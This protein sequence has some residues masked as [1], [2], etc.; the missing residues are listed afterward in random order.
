MKTLINLLVVGGDSSLYISV[1]SY[2]VNRSTGVHKRTVS[3]CDN[4]IFDPCFSWL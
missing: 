3:V 2:G 4:E 1:Y